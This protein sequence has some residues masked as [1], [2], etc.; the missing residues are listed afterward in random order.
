[1]NRA[2]QAALLRLAAD[3]GARG[4]IVRRLAVELVQLRQMATDPDADRCEECSGPL[5]QPATGRPRRYCGDR[6][7]QRAHR[8][9][10]VTKE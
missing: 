7:R 4:G 5:V 1:V 2:E 8:S 9:R 3:L 6:C 10:N